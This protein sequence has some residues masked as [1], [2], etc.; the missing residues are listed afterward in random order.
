MRLVR[1]RKKPENKIDNHLSFQVYRILPSGQYIEPA[2]A[3]KHLLIAWVH[4]HQSGLIFEF[5]VFTIK[6]SHVLWA[7]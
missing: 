7:N 1:Q 4:I 5:L 3:D 6:E 2:E